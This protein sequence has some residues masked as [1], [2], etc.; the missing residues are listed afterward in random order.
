MH[1]PDVS[2][3]EA[4]PGRASASA[5]TQARSPPSCAQS[6]PVRA[7]ACA[8]NQPSQLWALAARASSPHKQ[9]AGSPRA[10]DSTGTKGP[11]EGQLTFG[12]ERKPTVQLFAR[13][14][15][16]HAQCRVGYPTL[17]L[18]TF[19]ARGHYLHTQAC[20]PNQPTGD[21][22]LSGRMCPQD[23]WE[24]RAHMQGG[25]ANMALCWMAA[26]L[27]ANKEVI[28]IKGHVE[29]CTGLLTC[30]FNETLLAYRAPRWPA[31]PGYRNGYAGEYNHS[32]ACLQNSSES[33]GS[34]SRR[35]RCRLV[36]M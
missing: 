33:S 2:D 21:A 20:V 23:D 9:T 15:Y 30:T 28:Q 27:T 4:G 14:H 6:P 16:L 5:Q 3:W 36:C 12:R 19:C 26:G 22:A 18:C 10:C 17:P 29:Q 13:G 24:P 11:L 7:R 25:Y 34:D 8:F 31:S 1:A 35:I 32:R